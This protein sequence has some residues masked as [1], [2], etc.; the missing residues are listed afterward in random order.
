M[1]VLHIVGSY[2]GTEVYRH[3][4]SEL[5]I[6]GVKQTVFVPLN[7]Q[8]RERFG[9][10]LIDFKVSSSKI[11]YDISL[12]KYHKYF[13]RSKI[14]TIFKAIER[15][16][17]LKDI[18]IIHC[19]NLC[20]DGSVAYEIKKKYEIPYISAIRNTDIFTYYSLM[21]WERAYFNRVALNSN[22]IVF[23][24]PAYKDLY[25]RKYFNL[26]DSKISII[27][28]GVSNIYLRDR[29]FHTK[30]LSSK[31][32]LIFASAYVKNKSL[33]E[34]IQSIAELRIERDLDITLHAVGDGLPFRK[35]DHNYVNEIYS[36][37][38]K[39]KW[40]TLEKYVPKEMLKQ[41]YSEADIYIMPSQPETFGLVYVE[42]LTQGLPIIYGKGQ[43][44]D[45]YFEEG[46]VGYHAKAFD[47]EDIKNAIINTISN[48]SRLVSYINNCDL[49]DCFS[50]EMIAKKYFKIYE[51]N[52]R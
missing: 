52:A 35:I 29:N 40:L 44:F 3:L 2:G 50:W 43:G 20:T 41:K 7:F 34:I 49:K 45:G 38:S 37:A 46:E 24:S 4:I 5:D 11:I 32:R 36:L 10:Q 28:N 39:Y 12:A 48:Y 18:N 23:I 27:P 22:N 16:V 19:A 30:K 1:H 51:H 26:S 31:I 13:I 25:C 15:N 17:D 33:K 42:A 9:N 8:N 6:L 21:F 14:R 47:V